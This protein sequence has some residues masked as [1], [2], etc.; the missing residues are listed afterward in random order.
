[1]R[2]LRRSNRRVLL[3]PGTSVIV[4]L[5]THYAQGN[6][7]IGFVVFSELRLL[8]YCERDLQARKS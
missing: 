7:T 1:M 2:D 6:M 4:R 5:R 3:R 8:L